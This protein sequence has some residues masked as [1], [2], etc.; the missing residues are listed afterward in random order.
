MSIKVSVIV[1]VFNVEKQLSRCLDSLRSQTY[2]NLEIIL[3]DDGS[4]DS[5]GAICDDY[6]AKDPRIKITHKINGGVSSARNVAIPQVT[7]EYLLFLDGDD[8]IDY[9]TIEKCLLA[10]ENG[11]FDVVCFGYKHFLEK[12]SG[13]FDFLR[14]E[15]RK[16]IK[17]YSKGSLFAQFSTLCQES[18]FDYVTDKIIRTSCIQNSGAL[19]DSYFN[20]GGEDGVYMLDLLPHLQNFKAIKDCFY[21]YYHRENESATQTFREGKFERYYERLKR[22]WNFMQENSCPDKNYLYRLYCLNI[23]WVYESLFSSSCMLNLK[24]KFRFIKRTFIKQE[25]FPGFNKEVYRYAKKFFDRKT[26]SL[27][28]YKVLLFI[29]RKK[30]RLACLFFGVQYFKWKIANKRK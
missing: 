26:Y 29:L 18:Y 3:V 25:L 19:F 14:N 22:T 11:K 17:L 28:E 1:P 8:S 6:A 2:N 23:L 24:E 20:M 4:T 7:G 16:P 21:H 30:Y 15:S 9:Q 12:E 13:T 10:T 27:S 5:S